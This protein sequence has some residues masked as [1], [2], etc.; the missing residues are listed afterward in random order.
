MYSTTNK[1][2]AAIHKTIQNN[3][4]LQLPVFATMSLAADRSTSDTK[5]LSMGNTKHT[6]TRPNRRFGWGF[7]AGKT[8]R[9]CGAK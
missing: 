6:V 8:N 2:A 4:L 1:D 5:E 3:D 9:F 7:G